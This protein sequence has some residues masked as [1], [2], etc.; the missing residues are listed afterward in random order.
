MAWSSVSGLGNRFRSV[1]VHL[2][3]RGKGPT[4]SRVGRASR[5]WPK[6]PRFRFG[7]MSSE[8]CSPNWRRAGTSS[9]TFVHLLPEVLGQPACHPSTASHAQDVLPGW[10]S[11]RTSAAVRCQRATASRQSDILSQRG[12]Y[13][14]INA[15][16]GKH[17]HG[18]AM[19]PRAMVGRTGCISVQTRHWHSSCLVEG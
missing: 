2:S 10:V 4:L 9:P 7:W 1:L 5:S 17:A 14:P 19:Q 16:D 8:A 15:A 18:R 11:P 13:R 3:P 12:A 6:D